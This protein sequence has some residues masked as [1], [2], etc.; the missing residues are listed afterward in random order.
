M[1]DY[2]LSC[3][4]LEEQLDEVKRENRELKEQLEEM[5]RENEMYARFWEEVEY[6]MENLKQEYL[7]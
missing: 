1:T 5:E 4:Y 2:W 7:Q 6:Q 3:Q